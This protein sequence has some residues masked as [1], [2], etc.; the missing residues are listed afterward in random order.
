[1]PGASSGCP[2]SLPPLAVLGLA[3]VVSKQLG[4]YEAPLAATYD[5]LSGDWILVQSE[6]SYPSA[7]KGLLTRSR[8]DRPR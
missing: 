8:G 4:L 3:V 2:A 6:L 5:E 7:M 1:M